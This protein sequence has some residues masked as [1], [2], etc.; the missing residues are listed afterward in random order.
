MTLYT[1]RRSFIQRSAAAGFLA[2]LSG[3]ESLGSL[4]PV[5]AADVHLDPAAV[6]LPSEIE[7]LV[8][9]LE[10]TPRERLLE[11]VAARIRGGC[12]YRAVLAAL[13]L[14][15]VRNVQPRPSVG[16]KFHAV[17]VVSSAHLA[18]LASPESQRLLPIFWALDYFKSAQDQDVREGN[19]T[20]PPVDASAIPAPHRARQA[21]AD[22]LDTWDEGAA[23]AA[24]AGV[25]RSIGAH[26]TFE[27]FL[28][29]GARD[30]RS[31]GHKA[32]F[33]AGSYRVLQVIGWR[34]AEPVLRS[35]A[36]AL[37][38]YDG[39][40]PSQADA[41][42]D[43]PGRENLI[44]AGEIRT[45]WL[46][47]KPDDGACTELLAALRAASHDD[48]CRLIVTQLNRG[49][50]VQS[51]WD[52]LLTGAGEL[53]VRQPGIV[54]LHAVTTTNALRYAFEMS[55]D[56]LT[57]RFLLLQNAAFLTLFRA[58]MQQRGAVADVKVDQWTAESSTN[59]DAAT[60]EA[61][62]A[63]I[64][65]DPEQAARNTLG[66]LQ[67]GRDLQSLVDA[68]RLL[69]FAKGTDS[70]DYKFSSAVLEDYQHLSP[71]WRPYYLAASTYKLRGSQ[72]VDNPMVART[73]A[74]LAGT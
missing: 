48:V 3:F 55:G 49:V 45:E 51:V 12:P 73:R 6:P 20:M 8:R 63:Q 66:Y 28:R 53:L 42:A 32:I 4:P 11:E 68:A 39:T 19:W 29:Y 13:L 47:G 2:G 10:Q 26:D 65:R 59:S 34:Y 7:P 67:A 16:F 58:A 23:D 36:Y 50:A 60:A 61:I 9:L 43:R 18:S 74:A 40:N 15:G 56:D 31:I 33:V 52:G 57:R 72:E 5:A 24:A 41:E 30:F 27:L 71:K 35:L 62:L 22:A 38:M 25:A 44:R 21:L 69:V 17:L 1:T 14:A 54:A 46:D 37:L 64:G 70:H